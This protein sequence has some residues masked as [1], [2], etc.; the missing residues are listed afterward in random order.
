MHSA[1][2]RGLSV[3]FEPRSSAQAVRLYLMG[4]FY[5]ITLSNTP[6]KLF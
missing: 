1:N 2:L 4:D 5:T 6:S 3:I